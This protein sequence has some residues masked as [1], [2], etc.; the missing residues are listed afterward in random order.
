MRKPIIDNFDDFDVPEEENEGL[1]DEDVEELFF[2][3]MAEGVFDDEDDF[4]I[5]S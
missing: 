5:L 4:P 2:F 3:G 1:E